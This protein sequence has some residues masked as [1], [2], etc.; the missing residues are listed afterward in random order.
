MVPL[1]LYDKD[2]QPDIQDGLGKPYQTAFRFINS[3]AA[4][5]AVDKGKDL[6]TNMGVPSMQG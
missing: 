2:R 3:A 4:R 5:I 1:S 6:H